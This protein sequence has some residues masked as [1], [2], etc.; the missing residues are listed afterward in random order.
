MN[1]WK[2]KFEKTFSSTNVESSS[3]VSESP[4][5]HQRALEHRAR[6]I[7]MK[8]ISCDERYLGDPRHKDAHGI[9]QAYMK[10]DW[11][12]RSLILRKKNQRSN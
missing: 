2:N 4:R 1:R 7:E 3:H 6:A 10:E 12:L 11:K 5:D 8:F 9:A